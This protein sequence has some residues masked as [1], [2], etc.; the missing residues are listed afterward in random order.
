M[1]YDPRKHTVTGR[2]PPPETQRVLFPIPFRS[3]CQQ[4]YAARLGFE[5]VK[6][7]LEAMGADVLGDSATLMKM[8]FAEL[9]KR[10]MAAMSEHNHVEQKD[11]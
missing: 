3:L 4:E 6:K 1:T 7:E 10:I 9:E 11:E 2:I 8:D 5:A